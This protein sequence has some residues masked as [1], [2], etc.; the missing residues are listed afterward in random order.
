MKAINQGFTK[1]ITSMKRIIPF[2]LLL[3]ILLSSCEKEEPALSGNASSSVFE[4]SI[5]RSPGGDTLPF[6]NKVKFVNRSS[7]AFAWLW[8][9]GDATQSVLENPEHVYGTGTS[10][11]VSLTSIGKAG[12]NKSTRSIN[13]SSPCEFPAFQLLT[14]CGNKKWNLSPENDA[15]RVI[16]GTDTLSSVAPATCQGDDVYTFSASGAFTYESKGQTYVNGSCQGTKSNASSFIMLKNEAG[17]PKLVLSAV[18]GGNP[19]IGRADEVVGNS[20]EILSVS[21]EGFRLRSQLSDGRQIISKFVSASLSPNSVKL[22]L[23]GGS[24]KTWRLDSLSSAPITAGLEANPTQYY[25]G[26]PL[27]PCQKDDWYT[28]TMTDSVYVNCNGSTLQPS[29]GYTCGDDESF[30]AKF[31]FGAV[32]GSVDGL[33]QLSL[34]AN[35]PSRWI[36]ILDR[37]NENVYRILEISS[38]SMTLRSGNGSGLIHTMKFVVK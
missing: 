24:R 3:G 20:Y 21:D 37:G 23:T 38:S 9:F 13:L 2:G 33:A 22:F 27:A 6:S 11:L 17:F 19:F 31:G 7:D 29:Q 4:F 12:N 35:D 1:E 15:I 36:G 16:S 5:S 10:F 34:P 32:S 8:D 18:D 28:F 26:G 30:N 14:G 25:A